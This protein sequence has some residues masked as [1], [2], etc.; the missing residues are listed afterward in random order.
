M[1][2]AIEKAIAEFCFEVASEPLTFFSEADLQCLLFAKLL[3]RFPQLEETSLSRGPNA[4]GKYR[5]QKVHREYGIEDR[6]R[7][8]IVIFSKEEVNKID[9]P[10]LTINKKYIKP[11]YSI[12]L[13]TEK[14]LSTK[15]HMDGDIKKL[16]RVGK[17]GYLVYFFRDVTVSDVGTVSRKKTDARI[18]R[19]FHSVFE[20]T[21]FPENVCV[22]GLFLRIRRTK[23]KVKKCQ[24]FWKNNKWKQTN[25]KNVKEEVGQILQSGRTPVAQNRG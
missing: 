10:G 25:L 1:E 9:S 20:T 11:S 18:K 2:D 15:R 22:L 6:K 19:I 7:G 5:T 3:G 23:K 24:V 21:K 12:E 14:T 4:K 8:D 13:G 17:R 16:A